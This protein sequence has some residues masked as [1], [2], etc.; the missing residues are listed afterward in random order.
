MPNAIFPFSKIDFS[1]VVIHGS[2]SLGEEEREKKGEK[3]KRKGEKG[4]SYLEGEGKREEKGR[5]E[6]RGEG[7]KVN[8]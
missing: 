4:R 2:I 3:R 5:E 1:C 8:S 6:E 7:K